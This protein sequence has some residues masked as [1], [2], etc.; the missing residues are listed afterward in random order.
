VQHGGFDFSGYLTML[1]LMSHM[2]SVTYCVTEPGTPLLRTRT[3]RVFF[4]PDT[5]LHKR[6]GYEAAF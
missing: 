1:G 3:S 6:G 4:C 5:G 2:E